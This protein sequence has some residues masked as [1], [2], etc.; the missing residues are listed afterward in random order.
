M[1]R[2]PTFSSLAGLIDV[3]GSA[4][5]ASAAVEGGRRPKAGDLTR[6]GIEPQQFYRIRRR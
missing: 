2:H 1:S 3:I 6:L 4:I 5:A